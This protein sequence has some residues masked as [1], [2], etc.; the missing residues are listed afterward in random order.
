MKIGDNV[1][2]I[3]LPPQNY[4]HRP[5]RCFTTG[6][7]KDKFGQKGQYHVILKKVD[8]P[9]VPRDICQENLRKTRLGRFFELH[10]SFMCAGGEIGKDACNGDGGSPL[11]CPLEKEKWRYY[12]AG[13]V[14]W[15]IGCGDR[16]VPG[17][18]VDVAKFRDWIDEQMKLLNLETVSYD[19]N[20]GLEPRF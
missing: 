17:V 15:G 1:N 10:S 5:T 13:I 9:F 4:Q 2:T 12:H 14:A 18:Y 8:I 11:V 7:G 19:Q 3:C 6:W 16:N 20:I